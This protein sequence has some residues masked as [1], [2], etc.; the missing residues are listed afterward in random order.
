MVLQELGD[1]GARELKNYSD[2]WNGKYNSLKTVFF[3]EYK[4]GQLD[5]GLKVNAGTPLFYYLATDR[6]TL[7]KKAAPKVKPAAPKKSAEEIAADEAR[8]KLALVT[9]RMFELR[10]DFILN[11]GAAKKNSDIILEWMAKTWAKRNNRNYFSSND[12]VSVMKT[13]LKEDEN[14]C[15]EYCIDEQAYLAVYAAAPDRLNL[16]TA[17]C[18]AGDGKKLSYYC[19]NYGQRFPEHSENEQL[20]LIYS[21]LCRLGYEMSDEEKQLRD[22]T[23]PLFQREG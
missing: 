18:Y 6:V 13:L 1:I 19:R 9:E 4:L 3:C 12:G 21:F 20:D 2:T 10:R 7:Y 11:F 8:D 16:I 15:S 17:Y 22:G 14:V 5:K 23:H